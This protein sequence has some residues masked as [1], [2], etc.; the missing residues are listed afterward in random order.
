MF[1][2]DE[3][4]QSQDKL[5]YPCQINYN[6]VAKFETLE[7][8]QLHLLRLFNKS[9][10]TMSKVNRA[11]NMKHPEGYLKLGST[12]SFNQIGEPCITIYQGII[13]TRFSNIYVL[14]I[15]LYTL[16]FLLVANVII[17]PKGNDV[18]MRFSNHVSSFIV[19]SIFKDNV[20][21][22]MYYA[23]YRIHWTNCQ[24]DDVHIYRLICYQM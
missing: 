16:R 13:S 22:Y 23:I 7:I 14:L 20:S 6:Y 2:S 21:R 3:H 10:D 8:D 9:T 24:M 18:L 1:R 17:S 19:S 15:I 5:C 11:S 4:W 12:Q